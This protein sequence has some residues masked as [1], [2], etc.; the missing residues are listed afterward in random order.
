MQGE[1]NTAIVELDMMQCVNNT[2]V[3]ELEYNV[4]QRGHCV[5]FELYI[6]Q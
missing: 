2:G 6:T 5:N 4:I 1:E 3:L